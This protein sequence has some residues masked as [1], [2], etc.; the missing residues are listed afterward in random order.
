MRWKKCASGARNL[1]HAV[2][3]ESVPAVHCIVLN[4]LF[5]PDMYEVHEHKH[6]L[7]S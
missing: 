4:L 5:E 6:T 1:S 7:S 2:S 3:I